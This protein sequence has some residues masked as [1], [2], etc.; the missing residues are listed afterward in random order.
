MVSNSIM[1][2][3]VFAVCIAVLLPYAGVAQE[4]ADAAYL[5]RFHEQFPKVEPVP[6]LADYATPQR[7]DQLY[8]GEALDK[9]LKTVSN[10]Q[11][12]I[13]WGLAYTM[14]ALNQMYRNTHD[15]KYLAANLR[16]IDAVFAAR[17]DR[18]GVALWTGEVV[19]AWSSGKYAERGRAV[20]AVHTGM[21]LYPIFDCLLLLKDAPEVLAPDSPHYQELLAEA[22]KTL[23]FHD[24]QWRN[25]P[26]V[27]EGHYVGKNQE[28]ILEGK[29]LPGNRLSAM[30]RALW[31]AWKLTGDEAH[32]D[33]ALRMGRYIKHRLSLGVDGA[34]YWPYWLPDEPT[35]VTVERA[36]VNGEDTSHGQ[37]TASFPFMLAAE[38]QVFDDEDMRRFAL[39]VLN[40]IARLGDGVLLGSVTGDPK[41]NP[42]LASSPEGWLEPARVMPEVRDR[43]VTFYLNYVPTPGAL[44]LATLIS[45][46]S[47]T[48]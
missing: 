15:A 16:C 7:F 31:V 28:N 24:S 27:D 13:A 1:L 11:G 45:H 2:R 41:S 17:D 32:R 25:G 4:D 47:Q 43:I 34:Y 20:F 35:N 3:K 21:I 46:V 33:R 48:Q 6:V 9:A 22:L 26:A 12:G 10:E 30:G 23:A 8:L 44:D 29:I 18:T 39:T 40:G 38:G 42:S 36:A 37:L 19:P 14:I 5:T